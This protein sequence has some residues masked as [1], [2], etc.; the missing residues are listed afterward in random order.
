MWQ[1][2]VGCVTGVAMTIGGIFFLAWFT[3]TYHVHTYKNVPRALKDVFWELL[4]LA[5]WTLRLTGKLEPEGT[6]PEVGDVVLRGRRRL[7]IT[8]VNYY[9]VIATGD[10]RQESGQVTILARK[11]LGKEWDYEQWRIKKRVPYE[12]PE[13]HWWKNQTVKELE[14]AKLPSPKKKGPDQDFASG[15]GEIWG[16]TV[17]YTDGYEDEY[18]GTLL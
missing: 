13:T 11:F 4:N 3:D 10:P 8:A 18:C 15:V 7:K 16:K 5:C 14:I 2:V 9:D 1:F 6:I 12:N 17:R